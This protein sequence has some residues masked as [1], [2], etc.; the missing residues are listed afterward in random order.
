MPTTLVHEV[1]PDDLSVSAWQDPTQGYERKFV[2][3]QID[4][5]TSELYLRDPAAGRLT[6]I[7][8]PLD[9][10]RPNII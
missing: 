4:F 1:G 9:V 3:R 2:Q 8:K 10:L 5:Y 6:P 7:A